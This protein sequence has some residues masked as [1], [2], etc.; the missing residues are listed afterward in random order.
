MMVV[1][2]SAAHDGLGALDGSHERVRDGGWRRVVGGAGGV[3]GETVEGGGEAELEGSELE[4]MGEGG[5]AGPDA[6]VAEH[7]RRR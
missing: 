2:G 1:A 6:G 7:R 4:A 5:G 3:G